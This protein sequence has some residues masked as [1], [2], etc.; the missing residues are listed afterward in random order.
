MGICLGCPKQTEDSG[1]IGDCEFTTI[2]GEDST[3]TSKDGSKSGKKSSR[4]RRLKNKNKKN[5]KN[6]KTASEEEDDNTFEDDGAIFNAN[7]CDCNCIKKS[8]D[9]AC[10]CMCWGFIDPTDG[11]TIGGTSTSKDGKSGKKSSRRRRH[12]A[13]DEEDDLTVHDEE[14]SHVRSRLAKRTDNVDAEASEGWHSWLVNSLWGNDDDEELD[15]EVK[16]QS[17][18]K[19]KK[20]KKK[21]SGSGKKNK[22]SSDDDGDDDSGATDPPTND[23]GT[24]ICQEPPRQCFYIKWD[25]GDGSTAPLDATCQA[26]TFGRCATTTDIM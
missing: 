6:K 10:T 3:D 15:L 4:R 5:K 18:R 13:S 14:E 21:K 22:K 26:N 12:L 24:T 16:H 23:D 7:C 11:T 2:P 25:A 1:S 17:E 9:D 20:K 8:P 19:L